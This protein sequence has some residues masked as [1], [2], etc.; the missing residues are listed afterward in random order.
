MR[1]APGRFDAERR[2]FRLAF[3]CERCSQ[4]DPDAERCAY[5]YPTAEHRLEAYDADP[6][7]LVVFCK[8]FDLA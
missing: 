4:F 5:G 3:T 1:L 7:A 2:R 6:G 8:D